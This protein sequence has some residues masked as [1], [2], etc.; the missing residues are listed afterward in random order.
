MTYY[1]IFPRAAPAGSSWLQLEGRFRWELGPS[2]R[3]ALVVHL[4]AARDAQTPSRAGRAAS[5]MRC[6]RKS[7]EN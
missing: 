7:S 4:A 1:C 5:Q 6:A 3:V 2:A